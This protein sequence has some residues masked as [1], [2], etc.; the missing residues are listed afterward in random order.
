MYFNSKLILT[1][2]ATIPSTLAVVNGKCTG[3]NGICISTANCSKYNGQ[4]FTGK[5]PKD[6]NN[7]KCC[8]NI[9]CTANDGRKG[10]CVFTSQCSG[11]AISGKCPGGSDFKC[12]VQKPNPIGKSCTYDGLNGSCQYTNNCSGFTVSGLCPGDGNIKCCLP[13]QSCKKDGT[14]GSCLPTDQC[15]TGYTVAGLCSGGNNIKCCLPKPNPIGKSCTYDGL[16]GSCQYTKNCSGFTVSGLCPGDGNIKCCLPKQ[17]CKKDGTNGSCL[18]TDQCSTGYTVAGLCSGGN[19]IKCCLPKPT[20]INDKC[21]SIGGQCMNPKNCHGE[22]KNDLCPGGNDNKCCL[23]TTTTTSAKIIPVVATITPEIDC[24]KQI[25][26]IQSSHKTLKN[27]KN[28]KIIW[29]FLLKKIKNEYGVA[30]MMGNLF[31]ESY[32]NPHQLQ[33][34]LY[35]DERKKSEQYTTK[36][37]NGTYTANEFINDSK[38]Y[39]LAQWTLDARKGSL[40]YYAKEVKK[41]IGSLSMQ[42]DYLWKEL[43]HHEMKYTDDEGNEVSYTLTFDVNVTPFLKNATSISDISR[44][45]LFKFENPS[46]KTQAVQD[47]RYCYSSYYYLSYSKNEI[48]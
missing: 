17:S 23:P 24:M 45:V 8:D 20:P 33:N 3:R 22:I 42:L 11:E 2:L 30:G 32:L 41:S 10:S 15:S 44:R 48:I 1:L 40:Y 18:P 13:K 16:N 7:I 36:V 29:N 6:V 14:N 47:I 43:T 26:D 39:G 21:L 28:E 38:G 4:S 9:P 35:D 25:N 31:A 34:D 5:C 19:S 46:N 12:C 37:T 27:E